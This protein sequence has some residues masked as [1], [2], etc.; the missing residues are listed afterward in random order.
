MPP[1]KTP[2]QWAYEHT[3]NLRN[4]Y[5]EIQKGPA[6][7]IINEYLENLTDQDFK[8]GYWTILKNISL[9]YCLN[10]FGRILKNNGISDTIFLDPFCGSGITPL[11]DPDGI[12][13][14]RTVG[15]PII[16]TI[17]TDYPF[18]SYVFGDIN[19]KSINTL[20][21][22]FSAN[23]YYNL[24]ISVYLKDANKLI[25]S[26]CKNK[27]IYVFAFLDQSG[28]QL[29]WDSLIQLM[30]LNIFDILL[31]FQ[32]REV[33]RFRSESTS[34]EKR[35]AFFGPAFDDLPECSNCDE[36]LKTYCDNISKR[37]LHVT[38][39]KIGKD[40]SK[41]YYYHLLHISR[42]DTYKNIVND[43]KSK[44]ESFK[45]NSMKKVWNDLTGFERQE[46]LY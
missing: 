31:N 36:I 11:K 28:F 8:V 6:G 20:D 43:L 16:S 30:N 14:S 24:N 1:K 22:I 40:R 19:K 2:M 37:N 7:Q 26:V 21:K 13:T 25:K 41:Q 18:K 27:N 46:S 23:N 17:M 44:I 4:R 15:S 34:I 42:K 5:D 45:G 12:N 9:A 38:Q 10:P 39:I 29:H 33:D 35:K 3:G 32:T